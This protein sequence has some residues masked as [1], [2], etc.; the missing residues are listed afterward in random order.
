[1][2]SNNF[3]RKRPLSRNHNSNAVLQYRLEQAFKHP[4]LAYSPQKR[5][6]LQHIVDYPN[7]FTHHICAAASCGNISHVVTYVARDILLSCGIAMYCF[8]PE[9]PRR[10]KFNELSRVQCWR[11]VLIEEYNGSGLGDLYDQV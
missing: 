4:A 2:N 6:V 5:R 3:P 7:Q 1:M 11:S 9:R 10:T 8:P